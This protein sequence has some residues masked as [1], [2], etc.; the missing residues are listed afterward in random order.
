MFQICNPD[1]KVQ[2]KKIKFLFLKVFLN[3]MIRNIKIQNILNIVEI[4]KF[5]TLN[6]CIHKNNND[7]YLNVS[8]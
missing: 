2:R 6:K 4:S 7:V 1:Q 3:A 5:T 8:S